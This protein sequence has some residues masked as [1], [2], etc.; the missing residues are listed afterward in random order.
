MGML[1]WIIC[2]AV[3]GWL[4]SFI[5]RNGPREGPFLN[6][7]VGVVGAAI[8]GY[9]TVRYFQQSALGTFSIYSLCVAVF[10]SIVLISLVR[11]LRR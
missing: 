9:L 10:G 7:S 1:L 4:T 6:V 11:S 8:G 2:G 5:L 3:T